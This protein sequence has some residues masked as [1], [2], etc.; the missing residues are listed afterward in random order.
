M[1]GFWKEREWRDQWA[2]GM[3]A[4]LFFLLEEKETFFLLLPPPPPPL[5]FRVLL[6]ADKVR[7]GRKKGKK[8]RW[9]KKRV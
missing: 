5:K 1:Y 8:L 9:E 7:G 2:R 6:F 3:F 4:F